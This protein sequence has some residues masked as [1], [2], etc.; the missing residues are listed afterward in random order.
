M[1][2][3]SLLCWCLYDCYI[4]EYQVEDKDNYNAFLKKAEYIVENSEQ[5][6]ANEFY[7]TPYVLTILKVI[8]VLNKR[9]SINFREVTKWLE[10]LEKDI[11]SEEVYVFQ[12]NTGKERE[13][14]SPKEIYYQNMAKALEKLGKY[15]EC[16]EVCEMALIQISK[17]HYRN[18]V[19]FKE[20]LYYSKCMV[21]EDIETA[22]SQYKE[23][24]Y[25]EDMWFMYHKLSQICIRNNKLS[26][27]LLY[28]SK[29]YSGKFEYEKM[30]NLFYDTAFL[31]QALGNENNAK[32]FFHACAYYRNRQGWSISE[33]LK[34]AI[35]NYDTDIERKPNI[36][37]LQKIT[38]EY[39]LSI[40]GANRYE[41]SVQKFTSNGY[42][43]F[44][45][46]NEGKDNIFFNL[47][48]VV[49]KKLLVKGLS[50]SYEIK[51]GTDG[52]IRAIKIKEE[53]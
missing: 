27:A 23:L 24:T 33:E 4:K 15:D 43:G 20:R 12:D 40:E 21:S 28:A 35:Y 36:K 8:R 46:P 52:R 47:K 49:G 16:I 37:E 2:V 29:A 31:W 51:Q 18:D 19:W 32:L 41:G 39:V 9:A 14:A 17:F 13:K 3:I 26:D 53:S 6:K 22:I 10:C 7:L 5:K 11:L 25:K 48:D 42:S 44:I 38:S 1:Y 45:K 50:V 34:F 30:V